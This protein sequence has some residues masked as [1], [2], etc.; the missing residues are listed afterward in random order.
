MA[1]G[2]SSPV[3]SMFRLTFCFPVLI[4]ALV[5]ASG[6]HSPARQQVPQIG[7]NDIEARWR[8]EL[9]PGRKADRALA[10]LLTEGFECQMTRDENK[11]VERIVAT[12]PDGFRGRSQNWRIEIAFAN[13]VIR[14][15]EISPRQTT[16]IR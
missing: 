12:L 7:K 8:K 4:A 6:C 3:L 10:Y 2:R 15:T 16:H 5:G 1:S 14:T 9:T 11:N 13:N